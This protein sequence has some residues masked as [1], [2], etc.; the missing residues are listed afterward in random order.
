MGSTLSMTFW[1]RL[2]R[3]LL[4]SSISAMFLHRFHSGCLDSLKSKIVTILWKFSVLIYRH[5]D[6]GRGQGRKLVVFANA[7][8]V[9]F[10]IYLIT[11]N[12]D[13]ACAGTIHCVFIL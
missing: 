5:I 3:L 6:I 1:N 11:S 12:N 7:V 10:K 4:V 2:K 9:C 8:R 13:A